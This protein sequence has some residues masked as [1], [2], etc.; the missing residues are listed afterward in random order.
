[1]TSI[2]AY[3]ARGL[4]VAILALAGLLGVENGIAADKS[5]SVVEP[6]AASE[7]AETVQPVGARSYQPSVEPERMVK[8][9]ANTPFQTQSTSAAETDTAMLRLQLPAPTTTMTMGS[10]APGA[11]LKFGF[12]RP[13]DD[14]LDPAQATA[15]H[16]QWQTLANGEHITRIQ[17]TSP[18]ATA[19]RIGL[20]V[21]AL[22]AEAELRFYSGQDGQGPAYQV[23]AKLILQTIEHNRND[24]ASP[25]VDANLY[26]SPTLDG[27]TAIIEIVLEPA[28]DPSRVD[29]TIKAISH[30]V[31]N[32]KQADYRLQ[33]M[34]SSCNLDV[35]CYSTVNASGQDI[36][37]AV[38][39]V[40]FT[41]S[42]GT[43]V[44]S[45]TL[46]GDRAGS[47]IPYFLTAN[48]CISTAAVA[49]TVQTTWFYESAACNIATQSANTRTLASGAT[50]LATYTNN[51]MTLLRLNEQP[52]S[53]S[54]YAGWYWDNVGDQYR[55]IHQPKGDWKKIS[56][57]S[58]DSLYN[59]DLSSGEEFS[60]NTNASGT[61]LGFAVNKGILEG[62][63]SGSGLFKDNTYL[64]GTLTGG[65]AICNDTYSFYGRFKTG[66]NNGLSKWLE[67]SKVGS[68]ENPQPT[69]YQSGITLISGWACVPGVTQSAQGIQQLA[70]E[71]DGGTA[72][73]AG[74]G[75]IRE[76]TSS[77]C[78]GSNN[79][80]GLLMNMNRLGGGAHS[81][82]ALADGQE[83]G[84]ASFTITTLGTEY[85]QGVSGAYVIPN[86]PAA[87]QNVQIQWQE[88]LQNFVIT[89]RN[90]SGGQ[91]GVTQS[92]LETE[93]LPELQPVPVADTATTMVA[94]QASTT[95]LGSLENPQPASYLSG[96]TLFSGWVCRPGATIGQVN[97]EI[98]GTAYQASYGTIR[99]DT[100]SVCGGSNNGW[101]LLFN[102]NRLGDGPHTMRALVDGVELGR[103][104]FTVTTL[105]VQYLQ[106][107][108]G[109]YRLMDFPKK[110]DNVVVTWQEHLQN[111]MIKEATVH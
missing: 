3:R 66:Y 96:I 60:C 15:Q 104:T 40:I 103:S 65:D 16:W 48:H 61:Y 80:W 110:G 84:N 79:G 44:C 101:G 46:V 59:C 99:P 111:F 90:V 39:R 30:L 55:A 26:W 6:V 95:L 27:E 42:N 86:F 105:G 2:V 8:E 35:N 87:N 73:A 83:I 53:G 102:T 14:L 25:A 47:T 34:A 43:Y 33:S 12:N 50:L 18:G 91:S 5:L 64:V 81:L 74:Y 108:S 24:Q 32:P 23:P 37:N 13:M 93:T 75:T 57:G 41:T 68:L 7:P 45:G 19:L 94:T 92:T 52:P 4:G 89:A 85:L 54:V 58:E 67:N 100:V 21:N 107:V 97:V 9:I 17:L 29:M 62:G 78:G 77:I 49:S 69:S 10:G 1:M 36:A 28:A 20:L 22:P 98:D 71:I 76:D 72:I 56:F 88:H 38:A 70:I 109:S 82:R 31:A 51:D 63:S 106:G 11:P